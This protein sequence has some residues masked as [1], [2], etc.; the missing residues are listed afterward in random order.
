M[1]EKFLKQTSWTNVVMSLIF[2]V[3]GALLI[4]NPEAIMSV[5]S[6]ILGAIFIIMGILR[7]GE[8]FASNK[9]DKY[10]LTIACVAILIGIII[11]FCSNIILSIFRV[12]IGIWIIFSGALKL[13]TV[14][15]WKDYKSRLWLLS[16]I[17]SIL[18]IAAGIYVLVN[19]GAIGQALGIVIVAYG[20]VDVIENII[21]IKK[22]DNYLQ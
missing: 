19:T 1:L 7:V 10:L 5:I 15:V 11:M 4:A 8:Y 12:I 2:I 6:I 17:F 21:F 13:Q 18:I 14:F 9:E 22:V 16:L 3:L 20:V